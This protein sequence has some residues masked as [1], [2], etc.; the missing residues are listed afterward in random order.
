MILFYRTIGKLRQ[1]NTYLQVN[2]LVYLQ[3]IKA[4]YFSKKLLF[5]Q[6]SI[7]KEQMHICNLWT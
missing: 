3:I 2:C 7:T 6:D 4:I 5:K 1:L